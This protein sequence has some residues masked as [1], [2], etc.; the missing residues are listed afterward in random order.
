M[1]L[2]EMGESLDS[3]MDPRQMKALVL[4]YVAVTQEEKSS[5]FASNNTPLHYR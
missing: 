3:L 2:R 5:D 4:G 1:S